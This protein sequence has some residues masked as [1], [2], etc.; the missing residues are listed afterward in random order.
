MTALG[1]FGDL[2][3]AAAPLFGG[4]AS[5]AGYVL[6]LIVCVVLFVMFEL[7]FNDRKGHGDSNLFMVSFTFGIIFNVGVGWFDAWTVAF[8]GLMVAIMLVGPFGRGGNHQ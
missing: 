8:V 4:N 1:I 7:L 6:G 3:N 2:A 5:L